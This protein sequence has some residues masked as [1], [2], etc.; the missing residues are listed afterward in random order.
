MSE[1]ECIYTCACANPFSRS[2]KRL[3]GLRSNFVCDYGPNRYELYT[4]QGGLHL[5]VRTCT[6]VFHISQSA[7][8]IAFELGVRLAAH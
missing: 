8:R 6:P 4:S 5:H 7:G 3:G 1:V 2:R